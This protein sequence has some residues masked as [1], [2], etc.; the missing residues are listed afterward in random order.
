MNGFQ[1]IVNGIHDRECL[2][3]Y[4]PRWEVPFA[5][6]TGRGSV[7]DELQHSA[8]GVACVFT[9]AAGLTGLRILDLGRYI[10]GPYCAAALADQGAEVIRIEPPEGAPDRDVMP[11]GLPGRG[12]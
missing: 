3:R 4:S 1:I 9:A 7:A 2:T 8:E 5:E 11:I 12:A 6:N 10:A